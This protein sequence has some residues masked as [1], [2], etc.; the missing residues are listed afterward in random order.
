MQCLIL[1]QYYLQLF[2]GVAYFGEVLSQIFLSFHSYIISCINNILFQIHCYKV[3]FSN[4]MNT[5][6][7]VFFPI[8]PR[9]D[10]I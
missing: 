4:D 2:T 10:C 7:S 9:K 8:L 5:S 1:E 3:L 6:A